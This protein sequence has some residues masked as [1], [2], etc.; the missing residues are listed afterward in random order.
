MS[1]HDF[2]LLLMGNGGAREYCQ[3]KRQPFAR[4][5]GGVTNQ[6]VYQSSGRDSCEIVNQKRERGTVSSS[7]SQVA[8]VNAEAASAGRCH[9]AH[10]KSGV[11]VRRSYAFQ[12][13]SVIPPF[14]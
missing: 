7:P 11:V 6:R 5:E 8:V 10:R 9:G 1:K 2:V 13:E 4:H 12:V 14:L 3:L